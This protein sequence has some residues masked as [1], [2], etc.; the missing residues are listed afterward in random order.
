MKE[1]NKMINVSIIH[2]CTGSFFSEGIEYTFSGGGANTRIF[3]YKKDDTEKKVIQ[4]SSY[5][6]V[7]IPD[8]YAEQTR[9]YVTD[10]LQAQRVSVR[11]LEKEL[12][13][14]EKQGILLPEEKE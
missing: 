4:F 3:C 10:I 5:S 8:I 6:I 1:I 9:R 7:Q 13:S 12:E 2:V 11:E 14:L